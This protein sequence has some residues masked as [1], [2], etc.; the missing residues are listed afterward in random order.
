MTRVKVANPGPAALWVVNPRKRKNKTMQTKKRRTT[1]ATGARRVVRRT[2]THHRKRNAG[3]F[4][5]AKKRQRRRYLRRGAVRR[6]MARKTGNPFGSR[7]LRVFRGRRRNPGGMLAKGFTLAG[8]AALEQF[9]LMWIPPVFGAS[10]FADAGRTAGLGVLLGWAMKKTGLF[11]RFAE[12]AQLAGL[13]LAGGKI[14]TAFVL[15]FAS[16][17][18]SSATQEPASMKGLAV[19]RP[20]M[21]PFP[22]YAP[23]SY[24]QGVNTPASTGMS[25][26][27]TWAPGMQP[28]P[29]YSGGMPIAY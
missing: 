17:F 21:Q 14:I 8:F 9:L 1:R 27:A 25:A 15:P 4:F 12:D 23:N 11:A 16:R 2:A 20:G 29:A 28:F 19:W 26:L 6:A 7:I 13:T 18:I 10:A 22:I 3:M 24:A 5:G